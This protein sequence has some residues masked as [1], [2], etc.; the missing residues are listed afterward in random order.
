MS[1]TR[2]R[3]L[4][5]DGERFLV[6]CHR[7]PDADALGSALGWAAI[8]RALGKEAVVYSV[9]PPPRMLRFLPGIDAVRREP[10]EDRRWDAAFVMDAAAEA[11][12]PPMPTS[13]AGPVVMF[14]H[15]AAHDDFGDVV[16]REP[17]ACATGLLVVRV[18]RELGLSEV[19][20]AAIAPLYAAIVA[21][22]GGFRYDGTGPEV[23]RLAAELVG[24]GAEPWTT[25]YHLFEGW[26]P[27]RMRLLGAILDGMSM[28]LDDRV[29]VLTVTR[30]MLARTGADGEMVEGMVNYGR[31]LEGVEI[32]VLLW[33]LERAGGPETKVSLRSSGR[34]DVSPIAA[35]LDGGGHRA[36]AGANVRAPIDATRDRVLALAA[37]VL[38]DPSFGG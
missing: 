9:D 16:L 29:A 22:T 18:M 38:D 23:L 5:R 32:A 26:H 11:L 35:A 27:A 25:A 17:D 37:D 28:A 34:A 36:A 33:E 2:V 7:R 3:A 31:M 15:H 13:L 30:A 6:T 4:V 14:D 12:V 20:P 10:P 24:A 8:L 1:R 21:D 19:P